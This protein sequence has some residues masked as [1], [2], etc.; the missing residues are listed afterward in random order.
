MFYFIFIFLYLLFKFVQ[1][2]QFVL[3][4]ND[5]AG[6]GTI[7]S[8][9]RPEVISFWNFIHPPA[10][11]I[12]NT[13]TQDDHRKTSSMTNTLFYEKLRPSSLSLNQ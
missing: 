5:T 12:Y 4:K 9:C 6:K 13:G 1:V 8:V 11:L 2:V 3:E 10:K 7:Y